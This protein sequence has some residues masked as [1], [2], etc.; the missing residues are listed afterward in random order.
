MVG[1]CGHTKNSWNK[2]SVVNVRTNLHLS[3]LIL[4]SAVLLGIWNPSS[5]DL[6]ALFGQSAARATYQVDPFWPKPLPD[7]WVTG[8]V[9]GTCVDKNDPVFILNRTAD[10]DRKSTRLNSSHANISY[11]VFC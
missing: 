3:V 6:N 7:D 4:A 5:R 2:E 10:P 11:A 1:L 9:G 8:N